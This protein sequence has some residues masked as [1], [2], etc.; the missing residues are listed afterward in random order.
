[1]DLR[2]PKNQKIIL[3]VLLGFLLVYFWHSR[4][5]SPKNEAIQ[6]KQMQYEIILTDLKNV[7]LKAKSFESLKSEYETLLEK[8]KKVEQLLPEE[9]QVPLLLTQLHRSAQTTQ[10]RIT[11]IIPKGVVPIDFYNGDVYSIQMTGTFHKLGDLFES[12]ANFPF[13]A[14]VTNVEL[15]SMPDATGSNKENTLTAQFELSN[16]FIR[17]QDRLKRINF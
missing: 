12:V 15:V 17:E 13:I 2:D 3:A 5:Y 9:K 7:E 1:M 8:Y 10:S 16:Y 11:Q 6:Q 4:I 14:N